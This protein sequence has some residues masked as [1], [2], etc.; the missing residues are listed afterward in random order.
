MPRDPDVL[1]VLEKYRP[2]ITALQ[3][4]VVGRSVVHLNGTCRFNEC[5]VG[6]FI[7]DAMV[8]QYARDYE[9]DYWTDAAVA[10]L[11]SGGIR[12]SLDIGNVTMYDLTT[13]LPFESN[14]VTIDV[15]GAE[16]KDALEHSVYR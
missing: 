14:T 8:F 16:L 13:L 10:L 6:N 15:T 3:T 12:T 9:G 1:T 5:N 11:Q 7:T 2:G 4:Q